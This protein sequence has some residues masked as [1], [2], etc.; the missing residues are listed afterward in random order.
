MPEIH[1]RAAS[2]FFS[3]SFFS[4]PFRS[5]GLAINL[6]PM[7]DLDDLDH[8]FDIRYGV[9]DAVV[10]LPQAVTLLCGEL[11]GAG[12]TRVVAQGVD[13]RENAP[14]IRLRDVAQIP[15]HGRLESQFIA[16]HRL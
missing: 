9:Q 3:A 11:F 7:T 1:K 2:L 14:Y 12:R 10:A 13:A 8:D 5:P 4:S 6:A 15:G 16:C